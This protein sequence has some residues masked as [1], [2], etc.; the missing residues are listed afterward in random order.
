M[1]ILMLMILMILMMIKKLEK[2]S[3]CVSWPTISIYFKAK[4][5]ERKFLLFYFLFYFIVCLCKKK[6]RENW[7]GCKYYVSKI[8]AVTNFTRKE[9]GINLYTQ[10]RVCR[11]PPMTTF[12]FFLL[13]III[14][15]PCV[16]SSRLI[17]H[18]HSRPLVDPPVSLNW[19]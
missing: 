14:F 8:L 5:E 12:F 9:A 15:P 2:S 6:K 13:S 3:V 17:L 18:P 4:H 16:N 7:V 19:T 1:M 10:L 11:V